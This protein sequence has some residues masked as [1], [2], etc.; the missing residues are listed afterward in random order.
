MAFV[1]VASMEDADDL[2]R[3]GL[4]WYRGEYWEE[5]E[6]PVPYAWSGNAEDLPSAYSYAETKWKFCIM[7]EE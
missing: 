5:G 4:L 2:A 3:A 7:T 6:V 1:N